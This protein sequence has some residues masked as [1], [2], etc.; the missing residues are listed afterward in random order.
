[1]TILRY[2][3]VITNEYGILH[4]TGRDGS[5]S[6]VVL[7]N[8][9]SKTEHEVDFELFASYVQFSFRDFIITG[10]IT[11]DSTFSIKLLSSR[12]ECRYRDIIV[13]EGRMDTQSDYKEN[14]E[15]GTGYVF[16]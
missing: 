4:F 14:T 1:M 2:K 10:D 16:G 13:F 9:E 11:N 12:D 3:E 6:K 5:I 7:T 15:S 8:Q